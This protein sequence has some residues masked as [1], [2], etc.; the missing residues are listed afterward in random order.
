MWVKCVCPCGR[1]NT[2]NGNRVCGKC[3]KRLVVSF[4]RVLEAEKC[5][6]ALRFWPDELGQHEVTHLHSGTKVRGVWL[7]ME[8]REHREH[9]QDRR[10][11]PESHENGPVI[12]WHAR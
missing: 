5:A 4:Q 12:I 8:A 6:N 9:P 3:G 7:P 11:R 1:Y 10:R 2:F